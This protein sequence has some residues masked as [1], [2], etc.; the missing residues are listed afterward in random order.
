[1]G[2]DPISQQIVPDLPTGTTATLN[3]LR[4]FLAAETLLFAL[5]SLLHRGILARGFQHA[6]AAIAESV[7]A[8]VLAIG[9]AFTVYSPTEARTAALW[10]QGFA[11][12]GVCVGMVMI[13]IGVGPRSG[14]DYGIHAVMALTLIGGVMV[15]R[16]AT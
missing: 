6:K 8:L 11:L 12:V 9:F 4:S 10:T 15:A 7:I 1:M 5:A 3:R 16:K 2:S 13:F 14:L